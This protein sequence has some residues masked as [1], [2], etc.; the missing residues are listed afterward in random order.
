M[1]AEK[2]MPCFAAVGIHPNDCT[3][4]WRTDIAELKKLITHHPSKIV[5][6]GE[7]GLDFHYPEYDSIRQKDAFRWQIELALS[8]N[9]PL[10]VHTRKAPE[11]TLAVLDEFK[12]ASLR[13][14]IHCFSEDRAFA[15]EVMGRGF[16]MGIGGPLTY[17]KNDELRLVFTQA[18]LSAI[19]LET[20]APYLAPQTIRGKQNSPS[21]IYQIAQF[22]AQL[23]SEKIEIIA[24]QTTQNAKL[25]FNTMR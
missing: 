23:R 21:S 17:P 8:L 3:A 10:I 11:E 20:D 18:P 15:Q 2:F 9:L 4:D 6:I 12:D 24:N 1:L 5:A 14:V 19:L 16:L 13:G 22:L 25:L 7:C